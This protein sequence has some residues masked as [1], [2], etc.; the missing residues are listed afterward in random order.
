MSWLTSLIVFFG[1]THK[2]SL[3]SRFCSALLKNIG[4]KDTLLKCGGIILPMGHMS[5]YVTFALSMDN[6]IQTS[7]PNEVRITLCSHKAFF[8]QGG[9]ILSVTSSIPLI[10]WPSSRWQC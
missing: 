1:E 6:T 3:A 4:D 8:Y 5:L 7:L 9:L 2:H 10:R